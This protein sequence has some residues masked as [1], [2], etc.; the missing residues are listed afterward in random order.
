MKRWTIHVL[1][2]LILLI[3]SCSSQK[4][5]GIS[6]SS[7]INWKN[8]QIVPRT[9]N[10]LCAEMSPDDLENWEN[11]KRDFTSGLAIGFLPE[12]IS[13]PVRIAYETYWVNSNEPLSFDWLFWYPGENEMPV[14][15]RLFILLDDRQ[16]NNA[17]PEPGLYNDIS[18]ERGADISI[19]VK[20]PPL[21][22]GIH[23]L[24]AIGIP[25]PQNDPDVYG[26]IIV[27]Y[28]R[29]TLIVDSTPS[30]FR[31]NAFT[32]LSVEGSIKKNDPWLAL[33]L[34][35][36]NN[37]V[38]VWNWP[39]PWLHIQTNMSTPFYA[40]TGYQDVTNLDAPPMDPLDES[41]F[42]IL[43]FT[44]YQQIETAPSQMAF[45]G[46][47]SSDT[48]FAR[49]PLEIPRLPEGKHH[50][51]VLRIDTPGVPMCLLAGDSKGRIIPNSIYGKLVGIEVLPAK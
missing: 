29:I 26:T 15:L 17:L 24:V 22:P 3:S 2:F 51:L 8:L 19:K 21:E 6:E 11:I 12:D 47:V 40:L 28:R 37:G 43:L 7:S 49:I 4:E 42:T 39:D 30:P 38:D 32:S 35:L 9:N 13:M 36:T 18:L 41:F 5:P 23:D 50:I 27:A 16:L 48:A 1:L 31:E 20:I 25:Y 44:D 33:E 34:T 45:Y 14:T 10:N 46:R